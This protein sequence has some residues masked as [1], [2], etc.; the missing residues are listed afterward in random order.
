[1]KLDRNINK[2]GG[3]KYALLKLRSVNL[4]SDGDVHVAIELLASRGMIHW[5]NEGPGEQFFVMK[6]KDRFT[7]SAL[8]S[9]A[10]QV[11]AYAMQLLNTP[12]SD[13]LRN[14]LM[15]YAAEMHREATAADNHGNQIP[16]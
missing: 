10:N 1:M 11:E 4:S 8:R 6:Y 16:T 9:Y 14:S 7:H 3:G 12:G 15:E 2:D 13:A 5:G